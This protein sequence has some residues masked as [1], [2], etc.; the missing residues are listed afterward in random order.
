MRLKTEGFG[1][2][3][4]K[5]W[6]LITF[7]LWF[8][9]EILL[10]T[11]IESVAGIPKDTINSFANL[12]ITSMLAVQIIILQKYTRGELLLIAMITVLL[13]ISAFNSRRLYLVSTWMFI[14]AAK[15][16]DYERLIRTAKHVLQVCVPMVILL[17]FLGLI[18]DHTMYRGT[19]LRHSLGFAHPNTLGLRIFQWAACLVYLTGKRSLKFFEILLLIFAAVF[20]Y[21]IPNSQTA[22][23]CLLLLIAGAFF[24]QI[25]MR[26]ERNQKWFAV[27]VIVGSLL[28][29]AGSVCLSLIDVFHYPVLKKLNQILSIR[30]SEGYKMYNL[31]GFTW[32]GQ[33]VIGGENECRLAGITEVRYLDNSY[34]TLLLR[35]G[36]WVYLLFTIFFFLL[37][38]KLYCLKQY[39]LL[40]LLSVN[41]VYGIMEN[42]V[43][44]MA[45]NIFII[46]M[47]M[48][49]YRRK[50]VS[51]ANEMGQKSQ[52]ENAY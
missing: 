32:L 28:V 45:Y 52:Q 18:E 13:L 30:F 2:I 29:N 33:Q 39:K 15:Y 4:K 22:V 16:V 43:Y 1:N 36:I 47:G 6:I 51:G 12:I 5:D 31:Y 42:S 14:V 40:L 26:K 7:A 19:D 11:T 41:A 10:N 50:S 20:V 37:L 17:Y 35:Y 38:W 24:L 9:V 49:V 21:L 8:A 46:T 25:L 34:L 27:S 48:L 23:F 44:M 3:G